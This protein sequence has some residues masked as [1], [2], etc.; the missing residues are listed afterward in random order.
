MIL[1]KHESATSEFFSYCHCWFKLTSFYTKFWF[2]EQEEVC[3]ERMGL[4]SGCESNGILFS[5]KISRKILLGLFTIDDETS[6]LFLNILYLDNTEENALLLIS[7]AKAVVWM[8]HNL[9][10]VCTLP[11]WLLFFFRIIF[12]SIFYV[13]SQSWKVPISLVMSVSLHVSTWLPLDGHSWN[14]IF[15]AFIQIYQDPYF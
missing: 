9:N 12:C 4:C 6:A 8:C 5:A 14:L 2:W 13:H 7:M 15:D 11:V 3:G 1:K 10:T